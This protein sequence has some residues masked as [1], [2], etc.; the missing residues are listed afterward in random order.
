MTIRIPKTTAPTWSSAAL[1]Y[2][3]TCPWTLLM[4]LCLQGEVCSEKEKSKKL[5]E[6]NTQLTQERDTANRTA[7]AVCVTLRRMI[8]KQTPAEREEAWRK[9]RKYYAALASKAAH[10]GPGTCPTTAL[11]CSTSSSSPHAMPVASVVPS[12]RSSHPCTLAT[13][14]AKKEDGAP[15]GSIAEVPLQAVDLTAWEPFSNSSNQ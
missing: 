1:I 3:V 14:P 12:P 10:V 5:A 13:A 4:Q 15:S 7:T 6:R 2:R 8:E 9:T 11:L